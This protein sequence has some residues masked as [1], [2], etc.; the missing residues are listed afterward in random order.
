MTDRRVVDRAFTLAEMAPHR[1]V[2]MDLLAGREGRFSESPPLN[3]PPITYLEQTEAPAYILTNRKRGLGLGT[4]RNTVSPDGEYH[5]LVLVTGRR[6]LC[7]VGQDSGDE[8]IEVPHDTV[9]ATEYKTG[10]RANRLVLRTPR[11]EYHCWVHRKTDATLLDQATSFI[12][13]RQQDTPRTN[14]GDDGANRV[15]YRGNPVATAASADSDATD[16]DESTD[17]AADEESTVMYRGN[18]VDKSD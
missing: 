4:K 3:E 7:L 1:S 8:V 17:G 5:T 11:K 18:P 10:F 15:M 6:T 13:A 2:T 14:D 16:D 9:V 12:E